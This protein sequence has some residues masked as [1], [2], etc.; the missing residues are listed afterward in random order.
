VATGTLL[1]LIAAAGTTI[2]MSAVVTSLV[3]ERVIAVPWTLCGLVI[4]TI[5]IAVGITTLLTATAMTRADPIAAAG[6]R[7]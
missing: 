4:A 5:T 7:E 3:G 1:G 2:S 6:A